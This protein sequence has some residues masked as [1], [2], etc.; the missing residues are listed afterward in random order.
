MSKLYFWIFRLGILFDI[1]I[2]DLEIFL[3][4]SAEILDAKY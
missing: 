1:G 4:F 3:I 2:L